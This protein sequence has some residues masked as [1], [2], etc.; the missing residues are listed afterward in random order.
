[1]YLRF[2]IG[3][4][5]ARYG[6]YGKGTRKVDEPEPNTGDITKRNEFTWSGPNKAIE[7]RQDIG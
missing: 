2:G 3:A 7:P 5:Q 1:M 4:S 6:S